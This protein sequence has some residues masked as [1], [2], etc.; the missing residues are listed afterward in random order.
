MATKALPATSSA[1]NR[2]RLLAAGATGIAAAGGVA[3]TAVADAP[4]STLPFKL[5]PLAREM[6][7]LHD[8]EQAAHDALRAIPGPTDLDHGSDASPEWI[9]AHDQ[10]HATQ[11][12]VRRQM[13]PKAVAAIQ[14]AIRE[15]LTVDSLVTLAAAANCSFKNS[16]EAARVLATAVMHL[17]GDTYYPLDLSV[18]H[19]A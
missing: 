1:L 5:T 16:V 3:T 13:E 14:A 7:A 12:D 9:A 10:W 19:L 8:Q 18:G 2:R 17:A 6:I 11:A 4:P 15:P